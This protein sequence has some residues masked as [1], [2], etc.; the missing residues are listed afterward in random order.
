MA[1]VRCADCRFEGRYNIERDGDGLRYMRCNAPDGGPTT[2]PISCVEGLEDES[3]DFF[4]AATDAEMQLKAQF[5]AVE[6]AE[7]KTFEGMNFDAA[8]AQAIIQMPDGMLA[9]REQVVSEG[10]TQATRMA[11]ES[12]EA[13]FAKALLSLPVETRITGRREISPA[14]REVLDIGAKNETE[15]RTLARIDAVERWGANPVVGR[16]HLVEK[17][18]TGFL[19]V[20]GRENG[21][22]KVEISVPAVVELTYRTPVTIAV[23]YSAATYAAVERVK[24]RES[25]RRESAAQSQ[26]RP[27]QVTLQTD[28]LEAVVRRCPP[29]SV[30]MTALQADQPIVLFRMD[31]LPQAELSRMKQTVASNRVVFVPQLLLDEQYPLL[32][33]SFFI[34]DNPLNPYVAKAFS[35]IAAGDVQ[36]FLLA[37]ARTGIGQL[38]FYDAAAQL[39]AS[40]T[41]ALVIPTVGDRPSTV[42]FP[43]KQELKDLMMLGKMIQTAATHLKGTP[44]DRRDFSAASQRHKL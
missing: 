19:G 27:T 34:Y 10:L 5:A 30:F 26:I 8:R 18:K 41:F 9:V 33:L 42:M 40:G 15:A 29:N 14:Q 12:A 16:I 11:G 3:C 21:H 20:V 31:G 44:E 32:S 25:L 43:V 28:D 36:E 24:A 6:G 35:D 38:L 37:V 22:Y 39:L 2:E 23:Q 4:V 1:V 13:A 7:Q 17:G